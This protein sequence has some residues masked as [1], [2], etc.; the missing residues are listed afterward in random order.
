[1]K[2]T[3]IF[4]GLV[5]LVAALPTF[6]DLIPVSTSDVSTADEISPEMAD[7]LWWKPEYECSFDAAYCYAVGARFQFPNL[8]HSTDVITEPLW[9][10][11]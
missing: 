4:T 5:A 8:L 2:L 11:E 3:L 6:P 9:R 1:M 10:R 7:A